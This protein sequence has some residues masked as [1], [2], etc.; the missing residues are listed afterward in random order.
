MFG[1]N[2]YR[3]ILSQTLTASSSC[4]ITKTEKN[5]LKQKL[6]GLGIENNKPL[7]S[8]FLYVFIIS[9]TILFL[10]KKYASKK[11]FRFNESRIDHSKMFAYINTYKAGSIFYK[12]LHNIF[13]QQILAE[14]PAIAFSKDSIKLIAWHA[15]LFPETYCLKTSDTSSIKNISVFLKY[16][17]KNSLL[18]EINL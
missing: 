9:R 15:P 3:K 14:S 2:K 16:F 13:T 1:Y 7:E 12:C 8:Q 11:N 17:T 18:L 10:A 4:D 6:L 5:H